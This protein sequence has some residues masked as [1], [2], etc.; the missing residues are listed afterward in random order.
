MP[1]GKQIGPV[2]MNRYRLGGSEDN[3]TDRSWV[4]CILSSNLVSWHRRPFLG[5]EE[6]K[7]RMPRE[8]VE[9]K[10]TRISMRCCGM[11]AE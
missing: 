10:K 3:T 4:I 9:E 6:K 5:E 11:R 7:F 2:S 1:K 8:S